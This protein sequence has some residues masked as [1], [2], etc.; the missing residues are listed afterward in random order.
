MRL[1]KQFIFHKETFEN[2]KTKIMNLFNAIQRK[3]K[4]HSK[5]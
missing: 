1:I 5:A 2:E 3:I 4:K